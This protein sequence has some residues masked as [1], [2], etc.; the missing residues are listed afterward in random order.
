MR[1]PW[2][3][4]ARDALAL[5]GLGLLVSG[6]ALISVPLALVVAGGLLLALALLGA[7]RRR[8]EA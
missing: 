6:V 2:P 5:A 3:L 1:R 7:W 8:E 4:D